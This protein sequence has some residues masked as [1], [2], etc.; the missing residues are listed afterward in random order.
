MKKNTMA[1]TFRL[2]LRALSAEC[3]ISEQIYR[4]VK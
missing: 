3:N 2:F 1:L 4:S